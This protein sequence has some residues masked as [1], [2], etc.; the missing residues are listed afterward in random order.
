MSI[1]EKAIRKVRKFEEDRP[2][3]VTVTQVA[4]ETSVQTDITGEE[5]DNSASIPKRPQ[6]KPGTALAFTDGLRE[7]GYLAPEEQLQRTIDEYRR[8]KRPVIENAFGK[9]SHLINKGRQIVITSSIPA[10]GK[11][12]TSLNLALSLARERDYSVLLID[13]DVTKARVSHIFGLEDLPGLMDILQD[14]SRDASG[15]L[16]PTDL[17][18]LSILPAGQ[19]TDHNTELLS[20]ETM[21]QLLDSLL[22]EDSNRIVLLDAPPLLSTPEAVIVSGYAGQVLLVVEAV[23]T[24]KNVVDQALKSL[25]IGDDKALGFVLNK[26][27]RSIGFDYYGYYDDYGRE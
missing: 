19:K 9:S 17:E 8:I 5:T 25:D 12:Y 27:H 18:N 16:M 24:P 6:P 11:S 22:A 15:C 26:T 14:N 10:E 4:S 1:I 2:E 13:A 20:S 23:N 21:Q 7:S 3:D